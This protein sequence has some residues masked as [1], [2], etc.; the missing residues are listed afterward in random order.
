[1]QANKTTDDEKEFTELIQSLTYTELTEL[2]EYARSIHQS[3]QT[4]GV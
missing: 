4:T 2:L 1:M 3:K